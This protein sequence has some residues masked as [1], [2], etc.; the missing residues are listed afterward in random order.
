[1]IKEKIEKLRNEVL[2][3][4][5]ARLIYG[6]VVNTPKGDGH[7]CS[8]NQTIFG[9]ELGVNVEATKRDTFKLEDC[10]PYLRP[11]SSMT[12][13][14]RKEYEGFIIHREHV[15][16]WGQE[17][18]IDC[19]SFDGAPRLIDWLNRKMFDYR[20]LIEKGSAIAVNG[21]NNPYKE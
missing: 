21:E 18:D 17:W 9:D 5:S 1:M 13:E 10:K 14:E 7:L 11:M 19:F 12:E 16:A 2:V 8:I 20:G 15:N 3:D 4:L 6:V